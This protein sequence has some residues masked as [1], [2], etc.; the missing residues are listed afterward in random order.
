MA[1][2]DDDEQVVLQ[3]NAC[4]REYIGPVVEYF[5]FAGDAVSVVSQYVS[6]NDDGVVVCI[7]NNPASYLFSDVG[8]TV[9]P[10]GKSAFVFGF[11]GNGDDDTG[12]HVYRYDA[13]GDS[14]HFVG[15]LQQILYFRAEK[16]VDDIAFVVQ[17]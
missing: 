9:Y 10:F 1:G 17:T 14:D 16:A 15:A 4:K 7:E 6:Q 8:D 5:K 3:D 11:F 12:R 2:A 13:L